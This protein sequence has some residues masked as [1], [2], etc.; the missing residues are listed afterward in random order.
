MKILT[1]TRKDCERLRDLDAKAGNLPLRGRLEGNGPGVISN[2]PFTGDSFGWTL[3]RYQITANE[4]S[5]SYQVNGILE[6]ISKLSSHPKLT[7]AE[8]NECKTL[9]AR[10]E[11]TPIITNNTHSTE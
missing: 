11:P 9:V 7:L 5:Y 6:D 8:L 10:A 1:A 4:N 3:Y 2:D